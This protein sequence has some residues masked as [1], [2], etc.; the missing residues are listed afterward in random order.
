M[1]NYQWMHH[2]PYLKTGL[3]FDV[4][5]AGHL[6]GLTKVQ[7]AD[8]W[9]LYRDGIEEFWREGRGEEENRQDKRIHYLTIG[10]RSSCKALF[11]HGMGK[12]AQHL[13]S[14]CSARMRDTNGYDTFHFLKETR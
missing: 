10:I 9:L 11:A 3:L 5:L 13:Y 8:I 2:F 7:N 1:H 4:F 14:L 12:M 6:K